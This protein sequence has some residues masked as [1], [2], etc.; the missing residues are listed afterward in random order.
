[1][2]RLYPIFLNVES[3]VGYIIILM[4]MIFRIIFPLQKMTTFWHFLT[5]PLPFKS[6]LIKWY[7]DIQRSLNMKNC[8]LIEEIVRSLQKLLLPCLL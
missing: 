3:I 5:T 2:Y 4:Q 7:K 1:M 8:S 6:E